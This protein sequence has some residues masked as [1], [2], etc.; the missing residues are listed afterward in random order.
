MFG[1]LQ[2][3]KETATGIPYVSEYKKICL[4]KNPYIYI[5]QA[6]MSLSVAC[7]YSGII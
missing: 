1:T 7:L 5:S 4:H 2:P 3:T 6:F